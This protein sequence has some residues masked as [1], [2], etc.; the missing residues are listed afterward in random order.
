[1]LKETTW[2]HPTFS[3][4]Q[5]QL[6]S[7]DNLH[8]SRQKQETAAVSCE[9]IKWAQVTQVSKSHHVLQG[10]SQKPRLCAFFYWLL[11][12]M[13]IKFWNKFQMDCEIWWA[14]HI[15]VLIDTL[16]CHIQ[17]FCWE[18]KK[19]NWDKAIWPYKAL[20]KHCI[21]KNLFLSSGLLKPKPTFSF[22]KKKPC[23]PL[24]CTKCGKVLRVHSSEAT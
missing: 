3:H 17:T 13:N 14:R 18:V 4:T 16:V 12:Q 22:L 5:S 23:P 9:Y 1:M 8:Y 21:E 19:A 15:T 11:R 24:R 2:L 20:L 10:K 7:P 6:K